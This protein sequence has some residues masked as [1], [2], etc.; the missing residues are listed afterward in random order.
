MHADTEIRDIA[1]LSPRLWL[2]KRVI[3]SCLLVICILPNNLIQCRITVLMATR[4]CAPPGNDRLHPGTDR[5]AMAGRYAR[6]GGGGVRPA[7]IPRPRR[8]HAERI[9]PSKIFFSYL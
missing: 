8:I 3:A 2:I 1:P 6:Q 7:P 5:Q 4:M 9:V